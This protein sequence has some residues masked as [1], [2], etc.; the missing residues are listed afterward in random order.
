M[1]YTVYIYP[2]CTYLLPSSTIIVAE[3]N[4]I[5][6]GVSK[7]YSLVWD[8]Y[9]ETIRPEDLCPDDNRSILSAH[10]YTFNARIFTPVRPEQPTCPDEK[11]KYCFPVL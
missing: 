6:L 9:S 11:V 5:E 10:A 3:V 2:T 4:I 8:I 1:Q 7:I